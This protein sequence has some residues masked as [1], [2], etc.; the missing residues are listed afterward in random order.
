M[1]QICIALL[2]LCA[3]QFGFHRPRGH[4]W[5]LLLLGPEPPRLL[6]LPVLHLPVGL[7]LLRVL[8]L[9]LLVIEAV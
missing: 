4:L 7:L 3:L 2:V 1:H 9:L 5:L 6:L 8:L